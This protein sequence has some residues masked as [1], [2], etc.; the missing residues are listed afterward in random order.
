MLRC[1]LRDLFWL[2]LVA[3][4]GCACWMQWRGR[5]ASELRADRLQA[6][7]LSEQ[8]SHKAFTALFE[9]RERFIKDLHA[10]ILGLLRDTT[11]RGIVDPEIFRDMQ[12]APLPLPPKQ[13][14]LP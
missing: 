1:N 12:P 9:E 8:A 10:Q 6:E 13:P 5:R 3:A 4:L 11:D 2:T 7:L 14:P